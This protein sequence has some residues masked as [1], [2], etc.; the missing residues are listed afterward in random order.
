MIF[1]EIWGGEIDFCGSG[2]LLE[3]RYIAYAINKR[4]AN[5]TAQ[6][7]AKAMHAADFLA[8]YEPSANKNGAGMLV[9]PELHAFP[10]S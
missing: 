2:L 6:Q 7:D 3:F 5:L 8:R 9:L 10:P 4:G 1:G